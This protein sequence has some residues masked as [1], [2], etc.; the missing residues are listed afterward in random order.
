MTENLDAILNLLCP[1]ARKGQRNAEQTLYLLGGAK[2]AKLAYDFLAASGLDVKYYA[3]AEGGK[4]YVQNQ[5]LATHDDALA[6]SM[7]SAR[8]L[9]QMK[10]TLDA[11]DPGDYT[12]S[13]VH[14]PAG[15]QLTVLLPSAK[16]AANAAKPAATVASAPTPAVPMSAAKAKAPA[17]DD[18]DILAGPTVARKAIPKS[19]K[20]S[21]TDEDSVGKRALLYLSGRAFS[22]TAWVVFVAMI[23]G[24]IFS[25]L[26]TIKGFLCPD[27]ATM[28]DTIPSYCPQKSGQRIVM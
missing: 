26:V 19:L 15:R 14:T 12:L 23:L 13:L 8:L 5:S 21:D 18:G 24:V 27:L 6:A 17:K 20:A 28:Q 2:D 22:S 7:P 4:L 11:A 10:Q 3:E 25:V 16:P 9:R 1:G